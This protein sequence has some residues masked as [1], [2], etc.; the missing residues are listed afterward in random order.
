MMKILEDVRKKFAFEPMDKNTYKEMVEYLSYR[1]PEA[2]WEVYDKNNTTVIKPT[3]NSDDEKTFY[4]LK[5][6]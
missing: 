2:K 6:S 5:W 4:T 1:Y 3:F